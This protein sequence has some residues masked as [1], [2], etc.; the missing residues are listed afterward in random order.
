MKT[1]DDLFLHHL[2]DIYYAEKQILKALPKMVK[3]TKSPELAE[4]FETHR[5]ETEGQVQRLEQIFE[6]LDKPA[7]GVKCE[8]IE[9]LVAEAKEVMDEAKESGVLDAGLLAS[10]QAVEHYE[11]ARYGTM[12]AWANQLGLSKAVKL[13]EQTL[14]QEKAADR[15]LT[16]LAENA[17]NA[18]AA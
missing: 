4:A 18:E 16:R 1:M 5:Q 3:A 10:A 11:I 17:V 13:L 7:R 6:I 14:E 9:G 2:K 15:L 12:R 8:A